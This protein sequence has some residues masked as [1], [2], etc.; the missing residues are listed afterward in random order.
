M[1]PNDNY[2]ELFPDDCQALLKNRTAPSSQSIGMYLVVKNIADTLPLY[3]TLYEVFGK[4]D[5][6]LILDY[7]M[8]QIISES[9]VSQHY[10]ATLR[11]HAIFSETIRSDSYLS[12]FF[13]EHLDEDKISLFLELWAP[14]I[15]KHKKITSVYLNVDGSNIDCEATGVILAELGYDK[16]GQGTTIVGIMYVVAPDGTLIYYIQYRGS[17][18]DSVAVKAV[19]LFF[20]HLAVK[21]A[22]FCADRG[23]C[24][25]AGTDLLRSMQVDFVLMVTSKPEGFTEAK[26]ALRDTIRNNIEK[27]IRGSELFGDTTRCRLFKTDAVDS[28]LHVFYDS[29]KAGN[30]IKAMLRKINRAIDSAEKALKKKKLPSIPDDVKP[31]VHLREG[32]GP[33]TLVIEYDKIQ[34]AINDKGMHVIVTS[35]EMAPLDAYKIY[36]TRDSSEKQFMFMKS[37]IGE[38]KYY[39]GSDESITGKQFVA[40]VAGIIRNEINLSSARMMAE[41][42]RGDWYSVPAIIK[43]LENIK[44]KRLPG[45]EYALVMNFSVRDEF[46]LKKLNITKEKINACVKTQNLR[47]KG[48][49]R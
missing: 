17:V 16:S 21:I 20:Q 46:M 45:D 27:W 49:N 48:R 42:D 7:A 30:G 6:D 35:K 15:I 13:K 34:E 44:L 3:D 25:K 22:G 36:H 9:A 12:V 11:N 26:N 23:F 14:K 19:Y 29:A 28:Y 24:S 39:T 43:E 31:F 33:R 8:Y 5:T 32:R 40:F 1:Y 4:E 10:E 41:K 38:D 47:I 18:I 2:K 37:E